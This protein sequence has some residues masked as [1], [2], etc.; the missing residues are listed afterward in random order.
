M[1]YVFVTVAFLF[2]SRDTVALLTNSSI[3]VIVLQ[4]LELLS[5]AHFLLQ[6]TTNMYAV[7]HL[8]VTAY[9]STLAGY[10]SLHRSATIYRYVCLSY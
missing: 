6:T 9:D 2:A 3:N 1:F 7:I 10:S 4:T 5:L 8:D